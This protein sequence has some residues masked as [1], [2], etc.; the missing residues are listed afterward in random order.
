MGLQMVMAD[1]ATVYRKV[2]IFFFPIFIYQPMLT[3]PK[4]T[5]ILPAI[6]LSCSFNFPSQP[7]YLTALVTYSSSMPPFLVSFIIP[8]QWLEI[9]LIVYS[10]YHFGVSLLQHPCFPSKNSKVSSF[11]PVLSFLSLPALSFLVR[12]FL[13]TFV[14]NHQASI[15]F[16]TFSFHIQ[17]RHP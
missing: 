9:F 13:I 3:S 16:F 8:I 5:S 6:T 1:L 4:K 15:D 10:G 7:S 14:I 11:L 12:I 2:I 17:T